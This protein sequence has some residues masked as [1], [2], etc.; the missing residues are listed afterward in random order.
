MATYREYGG[1]HIDTLGRAV[2]KTLLNESI[3]LPLALAATYLSQPSS[4]A[5]LTKLLHYITTLGINPKTL[6]L[7]KF[8]RLALY[9]GA[10]GL[11]LTT[12]D[13]LNK[14]VANNWTRNSR[15]EWADWSKEIVVVTGGSSGIGQHIVQGLL[16][17]N[18]RTTIVIVDFAPLS[19]VPP[20]GMLGKTLHY[21][22]ADLSK[23]DVVEDVC[24]RIRKEVGHPTVLVNNAGICRGF[25]IADGTYADTDAT[26]RTNL[27]APFLLIKEFLPHMVSTNHGHIVNISSM[28]AVVPPPEMVDYAA[29]K[30]GL[31]AMHEGLSLELKYRY[32]APKVRLTCLLPNFIRT[33]LLTGKARHPKQPQFFAPL[34][35]V[36]TKG[37]PEWLF[38][39]LVFSTT[40]NM[41]VEFKGRQ[42]IDETGGL[43]AN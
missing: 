38:R 22:Q 8:A 32:K 42:K 39:T 35:D 5:I 14:W 29:S 36:E 34:L 1:F 19:W 25:T 43:M 28:S 12:N 15:S 7:P 21:Y 3:T 37:G 20:E 6:N 11:A 18:P 10:T 9:L 41:D 23:A 13:T 4:A 30:A 26:L 27:T 31:F 2:R 17:R 16:K 40:R 24:A 33:P